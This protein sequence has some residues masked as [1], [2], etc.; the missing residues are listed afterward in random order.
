MKCSIRTLAIVGMLAS[1][2]GCRA[3]DDASDGAT[4]VDTTHDPASTSDDAS[5]TAT[6][7]TSTT[8][9]ATSTTTAPTSGDASTTAA[10]DTGTGTGGTEENKFVGNITTQGM[11]RP[12]FI[13]Y[14]NQITPENEGKWGSVEAT[15]DVM[16]WAPLDAVYQYAMEHDIPFKQHAM[17]WG[18]QQP[19]WIAGLPANEQAEE[20]QEWIA[21]FCERYPETAII[22][23]V[24]E[25]PPHT[26]PPYV[27]AIG[28]AGAS[29]YDWIIW[30]FQ[31][32]REHCPGSI[33]VLNDYNV[34][35][36]DT[37]NFV[38][39]VDAVKDS[40]YID[41]L[42]AQAHGLETIALSEL[43]T[44]LQMVLDTGLPLYISEYDLDIADDTLQRDV[45]AE[46]FPVF[47][48]TEGIVGITLWGYIHGATWKPDTG[49]IRDDEHRP[50]MTWLLDYLADQ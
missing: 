45:M 17:V 4:G 47:W 15:R 34:L 3:D 11:V 2:G 43:Q 44:N 27:E 30:S 26:T 10:D 36:W 20:V 22:D 37:A 21:A 6:T 40:G 19:G 12:D 41:A 25:P 24:N 46:Q 33:L 18:S 48:Q 5:T 38:S 16:N 9:D 42:G 39:I 1:S 50:A 14:W 32:T 23:V 7:S 35:R 28:G 31:T 49:L 29:G 8:T 13:E